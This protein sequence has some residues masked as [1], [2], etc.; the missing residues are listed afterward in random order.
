MRIVLRYHSA[1][2]FSRNIRLG[3]ALTSISWMSGTRGAHPGT[4]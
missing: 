2:G 3:P 1:Y 4:E